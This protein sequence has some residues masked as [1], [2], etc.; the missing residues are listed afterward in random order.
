M[1]E[2]Y[3]VAVWG[4][5]TMGKGAIRELL[6]LPETNLVSVLAYNHDNDGIDVGTL[7]GGEP[8][9]V[10][11]TTSMID[12]IA[13]QPE[14]VLHTARDFGDFRADEE[15]VR[16]L[17]AGINVISVLPYQYPKARGSEFQRR[18][19]E[20]GKRGGSTLHGTGIDPGFL[21]ERLVA[22]MTGL[23]ND[24]QHVRMEEYFNC[25]NLAN[26]TILELYGF[27]TAI[28]DVERS[29]IAATMAQNY[30]TMGMHYLAD[31]LGVPLKHIERR[32]HHKLTERDEKISSGFEAKAGTVGTIS[33]EWIGYTFEERPMFQIQVFWY[34]TG[35]LRPSAA[36]GD[37]F[38]IVDVEGVPSSRLGLEL[39]GS[40]ARNLSMTDRNPTPA[41]YLATLVPAIQA[42]PAVIQAP[43]GVLIAEMPQ[44]HWK[45]DMRL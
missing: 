36:R 10:A 45:P 31:H 13:A 25:A 27:G 3:R 20:A 6:R 17:E 34:L 16:L 37:D 19:D 5:G 29:P 28:A 26:H 15:I 8:V 21:F 23:S 43:A 44:F 30:L 40:I 24:I 14:V 39:K 7:L 1:R 38:W 41:S 35:S 2:P 9:G 42:I 4:P 32:S 33:F 12:L 11:V 18:F 22:L